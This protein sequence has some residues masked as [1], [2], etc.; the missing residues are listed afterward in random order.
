MVA[1]AED[2][3]EEVGGGYLLGLNGR[4]EDVMKKE[5]DVEIF[6]KSAFLSLSFFSLEFSLLQTVFIFLLLL[7]LF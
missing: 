7:I 3:E 6:F 4:S 2:G 5:E 1:L